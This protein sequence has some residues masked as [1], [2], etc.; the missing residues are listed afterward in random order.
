MHIQ[1]QGNSDHIYLDG[2]KS[3][4]ELANAFNRF[5]TRFD[6]LDFSQEAQE[7]QNKFKD[8]QHLNITCKD[9]EN[10]FR[11]TKINTSHGPDNICGRVIKTC[12]RDLSQIFQYIFNKSL[13]TQHVPKIWKDAVVVPVQKGSSSKILNDFIPVALTSILM[14]NFEK[15]IRS[16]ILKI[17]ENALDPMQF[18]YR[19]HRG[20]EDAT[21]TLLHLHF[22]HFDGS[23]SHAQILFIDF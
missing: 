9:V 16:E 3:D 5:Y 12:A 21:L 19:P 2:F 4:A 11:R 8:N 18:A 6:T 7:L 14:K 17:T 20:V 13:Q 1:S 10:V 15:L 22:K 23:G